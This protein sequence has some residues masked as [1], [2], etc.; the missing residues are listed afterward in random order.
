MENK[1]EKAKGITLIALVITIV[2]LLILATVSITTLAG[3]NGILTKA[4]KAK[5]EHKIAEARE[6]LSLV[7]LDAGIEKRTNIKYNQ[8]AF[9]DEFIRRDLDGSKIKGD[10]VIVD[11][12]AFELDR[13]IPKIGKYEGEEKDLIFPDLKLVTQIS[14]NNDSVTIKVTTQEKTNGI[15]KIE[16]ILDGDVIHT[17][18]N[19]NNEK[20]EIIQNYTTDKNGIYTIKV[21]SK[22]ISTETAKVEGL[23]APVVY[24]PNGSEQYQKEFQVKLRVSESNEKVKSIKYQWANSNVEPSQ[25]TFTQIVDNGGTVRKDGLTGKWYL[26]TLLETESGATRTGKSEAFYFDNTGPTVKLTSTPVS[27][28]SFTL[29]AEAADANVKTIA[30]YEFYANGILV[31]TQTIG[32]GT[33]SFTVTGMNMG[34]TNCYVKVYDS[35]ENEGQA[36]VSAITKLYTWNMYSCNAKTSYSKVQGST[37]SINLVD[38]NTVSPDTFVYREPSFDSSIGKFSYL[39]LKK[40]SLSILGNTDSYYQVISPSNASSGASGTCSSYWWWD[41]HGYNSATKQKSYTC[42]E[43]IVKS[44]TSYSKGSSLNKTVTSAN[45]NA[46]PDNNYSGSTWYVYKGI[47]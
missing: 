28:S 43:Y 32:E 13:N 2:V 10:I 9:L 11:G 20:E 3:E 36:T 41:Y 23:L 35:L 7:L 31:N 14:E 21:Y 39:G 30:K 45:R 19:Y 24:E 12:Y 27:G 1:R 44:T 29:T 18:E 15:S 6:K 8:D 4:K 42:Y 5:E 40:G 47:Y 34:S 33:A 25:E 38:Y 26:W 16:V 46:Y 22:L 17:F 37:K